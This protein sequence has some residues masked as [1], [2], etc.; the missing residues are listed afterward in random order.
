[1]FRLKTALMDNMHALMSE[2]VEQMGK[3]ARRPGR[4][5]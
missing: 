3:D 2:A 5:A 1:M 4:P